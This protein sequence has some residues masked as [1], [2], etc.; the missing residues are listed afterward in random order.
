LI[1]SIPLKMPL[2]PT[3]KQHPGRF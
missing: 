1:I 2:L 3:I